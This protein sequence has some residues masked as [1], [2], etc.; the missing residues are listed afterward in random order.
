[1]FKIH[2]DEYISCDKKGYSMIADIY[3]KISTQTQIREIGI[4]FS[5]CQHF[6]ANLS[7][8][9]GAILDKLSEEGFLMWLTDINSTSVRKAL[10][11]N[12][13][14]KAF[15]YETD[16]KEKENFIEY[17]KFSSNE[18]TSF[19]EYIQ[20]GLM[21]K[22]R[23]PKHTKRA[24]DK[25]LESIYEIYSNAIKHGDCSY[26]YCCGELNDDSQSVLDVT[27]VDCGNTI[28]YNVNNFFKRKAKSE[29][30][31]CESIIWSMDKGHTT[32]DQPGGLG[33]AIL[34]EF[35]TLNNGALQ[36]VSANGM[37][38]YRNGT[39]STSVLQSDFPGTIVNMEF[40]FDDDTF[41]SLNDEEIDL[42]DLL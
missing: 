4:D 38:D 39:T 9:L 12:H 15:N 11:R 19:K 20:K 37:L 14:I 31:A 42:N 32:K 33:L 1:M 5:K 21:D 29:V 41:Y 24:G 17:K 22:E 34:K 40:N 10:S 3:R 8:A 25:V 2:L 6:D 16:N 35:I 23:F 13:F 27:I 30:D 18:S 36:I 28:P 7:A 26:V